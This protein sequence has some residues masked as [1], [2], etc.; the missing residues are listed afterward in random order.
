MFPGQPVCRYNCYAL[1][2]ILFWNY[3]WWPTDDVT[4]V[5]EATPSSPV[6]PPNK[7]PHPRAPCQLVFSSLASIFAAGPACRKQWPI[8]SVSIAPEG[9]KGQRCPTQRPNNVATYLNN[10]S[11]HIESTFPPFFPFPTYFPPGQIVYPSHGPLPITYPHS[12]AVTDETSSPTPPPRI[13]QHSNAEQPNHRRDCTSRQEFL[14]VAL[15]P[16]AQT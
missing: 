6:G 15:H 10:P 7:R 8:C 12:A 11:I 13:K 14:A 5:E 4:V 3:R 9:F 1:P 16:A 2:A